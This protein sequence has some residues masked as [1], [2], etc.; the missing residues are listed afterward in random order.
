MMQVNATPASNVPEID[1]AGLGS[2]VA[3]VTG[4]LALVER[5]RKAA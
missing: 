4:A 3:L 5:R 1:P 2:V